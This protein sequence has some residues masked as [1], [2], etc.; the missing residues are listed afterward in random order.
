MS[1]YFFNKHE[2]LRALSMADIDLEESKYLF[3][4]YIKKYP[5]DYGAYAHYAVILIMLRELDEAAKV[6]DLVNLLVLHDNS[7]RSNAIIYNKYIENYNFARIK[8]FC[9]QGKIEEVYREYIE[10]NYHFNGQSELDIDILKNNQNVQNINL[11]AVRI[12][13]QK[14]LGMVAVYDRNKYHYLSR[15]IIEYHESDFL[16]HISRHQSIN[17]IGADDPNPAIFGEDFPTKEVIDMIKTII[18]NE[19]GIFSGFIED[20]YVFK[21]DECGCVNGKITDYFQVVTL[22]G[23]NSFITM[24]PATSCEYLPYID[25]NHLKKDKK[26]IK[27]KKRSQIEKFNARYGNK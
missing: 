5:K 4:K 17:N 24:Y 9:Y 2:F 6:L 14:Q 12:Y 7:F 27:I 8:L 1:S 18:P 25:L 16:Y 20:S 21:Y 10:P 26:D 11:E 22:H 13:C 15:Q 23:T 3:Q 19:Q